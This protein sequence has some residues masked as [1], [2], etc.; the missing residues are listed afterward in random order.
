[1]TSLGQLKITMINLSGP[2]QYV[3]VVI[4][5]EETDSNN[6]WTKLN[7]R[8]A[9]IAQSFTV[10]INQINGNNYQIIWH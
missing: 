9:K 6:I 10:Q 7:I 5:L 4:W 2:A 1:M 8:E 3:E